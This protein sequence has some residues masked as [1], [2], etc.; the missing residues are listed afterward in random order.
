MKLTPTVEWGQQS[1]W[2]VEE[3]EIL[4]ENRNSQSLRVEE[5]HPM[6]S[7]NRSATNYNSHAEEILT[8]DRNKIP[9]F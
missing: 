1:P 3:S 6:A 5:Y 4:T 8:G 2:H 9:L 7:W